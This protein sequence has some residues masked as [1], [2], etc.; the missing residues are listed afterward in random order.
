[1][2]PWRTP[3][4]NAKSMLQARTHIHIHTHSH[5]QTC[6]TCLQ[7]HMNGLHDDGVWSNMQQSPPCFHWPEQMGHDHDVPVDCTQTMYL[8]S[9]LFKLLLCCSCGLQV[10]FAVTIALE[11]KRRTPTSAQGIFEKHTHPR[12]CTTTTHSIMQ[13]LALTCCES[14]ASCVQ[15]V[16]VTRIS[17]AISKF[18]FGRKFAGTLNLGGHLANP[19]NYL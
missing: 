3:V 14:R 9:S 7:F 10:C 1:M 11:K 18:R 15:P 13:G 8:S 12:L 16:N 5:T 6:R 2:L 19:V 4:V 17:E